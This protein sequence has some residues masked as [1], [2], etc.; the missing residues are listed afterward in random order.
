MWD[1]ENEKLWLI[2]VN[3]RISQPH[4]EVFIMVDGMSNHEVAVDIAP[5]QRPSMANRQGPYA[6]AAKWLK[7]KKPASWTSPCCAPGSRTARPPT[8][9]AMLTPSRWC[10]MRLSRHHTA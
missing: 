9:A 8:P 2:E 4:R 10:L 3:T 6:V 5:G 1:E 7:G